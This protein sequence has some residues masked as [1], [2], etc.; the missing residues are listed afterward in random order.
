MECIS[1]QKNKKTKQNKTKKNKQLVLRQH[2]TQDVTMLGKKYITVERQ[3]LLL[4]L[5]KKTYSKEYYFY[6]KLWTKQCFVHLLPLMNGMLT[7]HC[8]NLSSHHCHRI[9]HPCFDMQSSHEQTTP[10]YFPAV[11]MPSRKKRKRSSC[12]FFQKMHNHSKTNFR[13]TR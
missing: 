3:T 2:P 5:F 7:S 13:K 6:Q 9:Y 12:P 8:D 1:P 11:A 4:S 10:Q